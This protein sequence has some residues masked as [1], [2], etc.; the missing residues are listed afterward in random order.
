MDTLTVKLQSLD[1]KAMFGMAARENPEVIIDYF[2]PVGTGQGYT[3]L[4]LLMASFGSCVGTT[5]LT[6]L[7]F[8]LHKTIIGISLNIDGDVRENHPKALERMHVTLRINAPDLTEAEVRQVLHTAE[9]SV[10]PV[11]SMLKG[12][13]EI[14]FV[15]EIAP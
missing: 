2:P 8:R 10:C 5:I 15:I 6:L 3:S 1:D 11:W 4:E 13:V 9:E 12:N 14:D 7:R